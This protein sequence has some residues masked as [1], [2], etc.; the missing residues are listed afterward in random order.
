M[1]EPRGGCSAGM[2]SLRPAPGAP[3]APRAQRSRPHQRLVLGNLV[4]VA[5]VEADDRPLQ[6]RQALELLVHAVLHPL[7]QPPRLRARRRPAR[8]RAGGHRGRKQ[9]RLHGAP[10]LSDILAGVLATSN[11]RP[12]FR[13]GPAPCL[14]AHALLQRLDAGCE[15]AAGC[16]PCGAPRTRAAPSALKLSQPTLSRVCST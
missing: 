15:R 1:N 3:H 8:P 13:P 16:Q 9:P 2:R 7:L 10:R 5:H 11:A 14:A 4:A 6:Q 12:P